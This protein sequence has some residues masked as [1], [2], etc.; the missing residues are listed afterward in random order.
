MFILCVIPNIISL[1][2]LFS[3]IDTLLLNV[4]LRAYNLYIHVFFFM[5]SKDKDILGVW[6]HLICGRY[7]VFQN[8]RELWSET[9]VF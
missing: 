2:L 1:D 3:L 6:Y 4:T 7:L 5:M 8:W 9:N